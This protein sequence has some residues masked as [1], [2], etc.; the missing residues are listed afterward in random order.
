MCGTDARLA[1]LDGLVA[2]G[3]LSKVVANHVRL[4]LNL[5]GMDGALVRGGRCLALQRNPSCHQQ[6]SN[7]E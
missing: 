7:A 6:A 1:V 2:N 5:H 4:D 3:E